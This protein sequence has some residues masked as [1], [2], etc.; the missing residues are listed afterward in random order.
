MS[1]V[2]RREDFNRHHTIRHTYEGP[3]KRRV[4]L[5]LM[6]MLIVITSVA[7]TAL[8]APKPQPLTPTREKLLSV[9]SLMAEGAW[10]AELLDQCLLLSNKCT[11]E[12]DNEA[13]AYLILLVNGNK[14]DE[15]SDKLIKSIANCKEQL[16]ILQLALKSSYN[17]RISI[18][19]SQ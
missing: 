16:Q 13:A 10:G 12:G 19:Q 11:A 14:P 4:S 15:A 18:T 8:K 9:A 6:L 3:P 7:V 17:N 5:L 1:P 2:G